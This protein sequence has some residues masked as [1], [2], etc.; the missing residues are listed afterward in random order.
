MGI[1][2]IDEGF[3]SSVKNLVMRY[4]EA[5]IGDL[6]MGI[7]AIV[8]LIGFGVSMKKYY[9][10]KIYPLFKLHFSLSF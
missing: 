8:F 4:N 9:V 5:N 7:F 6:A 3:L 1:E 10:F 2:Y